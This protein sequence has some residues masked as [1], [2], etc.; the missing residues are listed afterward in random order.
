[1]KV[2]AS[3]SLLSSDREKPEVILLIHFFFFLVFLLN[4]WDI[5]FITNKRG[6]S[7]SHEIIEQSDLS[8]KISWNL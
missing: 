2:I 7:S 4:F 5:T 1:M 8:V 3:S 6:G